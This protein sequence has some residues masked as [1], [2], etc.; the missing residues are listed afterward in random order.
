M[1]ALNMLYLEENKVINGAVIEQSD[2]MT[3]EV[4][5]AVDE[6]ILDLS[7]VEMVRATQVIA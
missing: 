1:F 7:V 6:P 5:G 2:A 3:A 4:H